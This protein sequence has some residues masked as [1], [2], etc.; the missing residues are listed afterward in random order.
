MGRGLYG[1]GL[2]PFS[3]VVHGLLFCTFRARTASFL[4]GTLIVRDRGTRSLEMRPKLF[5]KVTIAEV[6]RPHIIYQRTVG[7]ELEGNK[8]IMVI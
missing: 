7:L 8:W 6:Q 5:V 4:D 3:L 2:Q 1:L